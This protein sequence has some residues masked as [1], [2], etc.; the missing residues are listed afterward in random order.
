MKTVTV[1]ARLCEDTLI[2]FDNLFT[3][4]PL[5]MRMTEM[6]IGATG[7]VCQIRLFR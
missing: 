3:S 5:L 2:Y 6:K 4:F 1:Q 7:T